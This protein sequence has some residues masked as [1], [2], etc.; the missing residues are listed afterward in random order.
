MKIEWDKAKR[1]ATLRERGLDFADVARL[2]WDRSVIRQDTRGSYGEARFLTIGPLQGRLRV[3][4]WCE[5]N[6][7]MRVISLRKANAREVKAYGTP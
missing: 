2:D 3:I 1:Q 7:A 5:R 4:V 6:D